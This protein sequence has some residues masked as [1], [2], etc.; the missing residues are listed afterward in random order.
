VGDGVYPTPSIRLCDPVAHRISLRSTSHQ[1]PATSH[2]PP[3]TSHR[4]RFAELNTAFV[5]RCQLAAWKAHKKECIT[6]DVRVLRMKGVLD[7][8]RSAHEVGDSATVILLGVELEKDFAV[9]ITYASRDSMLISMLDWVARALSRTGSYRN[10]MVYFNREAVVCERTEQ[11]ENRARC[12]SNVGSMQLYFLDLSGAKV[13]FEKVHAIAEKA[14]NFELL[15][16]AYAGL[17]S[18]ARHRGFK[19]EAMEFAQQSLVA[20]GLMLDGQCHKSRDLGKSLIAVINCSD[21]DGDDF[22]E[23]LIQRLLVHA[24]AVDE[25]EPGG[26]NQLV[27]ASYF[28]YRRHFAMA[29]HDEGLVHCKAVIRLAQEERFLQSPIVQDM[30]TDAESMLV[31]MHDVGVLEWYGPSGFTTVPWMSAVR[32]S[33]HPKHNDLV[34]S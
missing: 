17:S 13:T 31:H 27:V 1:P 19:E 10:S 15:G 14:G 25:E 28:A 18:I 30:A 22:D 24:A 33:R 7:Q 29:R 8:M 4:P 3:A 2:Q 16:K 23:T 6:P 11:Y 26:S 9:P 34:I 21:I 5:R 20:S 32:V 12:L